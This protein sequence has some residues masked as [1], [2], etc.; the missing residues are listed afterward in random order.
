MKKSAVKYVQDVLVIT[1]QLGYS[2]ADGLQHVYDFFHVNFRVSLARPLFEITDIGPY[3]QHLR[4]VQLMWFEVYQNFN[5]RFPDRYQPM[6]YQQRQPP[7]RLIKALPAPP[8]HFGITNK[9][10]AYMAEAEPDAVT[11]VYFTD[12]TRQDYEYDDVADV[13]VAVEIRQPFHQPPGHTPR[14]W[15]NIHDGKI[16]WEN[17]GTQHR[18]GEQ[19][20]THYH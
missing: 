3:M 19:G 15:G 11:A 9:P 14:R 2:F 1:N 5:V 17:A 12:F 16:G 4:D 6:G 18:C 13:Y 20:C 7:P 8:F 10:N